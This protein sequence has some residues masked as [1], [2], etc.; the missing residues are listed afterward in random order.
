MT[1]YRTGGFSLIPNGARTTRTSG[2]SYVIPSAGGGTTITINEIG[3]GS[4]GTPGISVTFGINDTGAGTESY[5]ISSIGSL[6]DII[7]SSDTLANIF[8]SIPVNQAANGTDSLANL[9]AIV[10]VSDNINSSESILFSTLTSISDNGS[11][12]DSIT[13]ILNSF[14]LPETGTIVETIYKIAEGFILLTENGHFTET[15]NNF[16]VNFNLSEAGTG[17]DSLFNRVYLQVSETSTANDL[18][19]ILSA[20]LITIYESGNTVDSISNVGISFSLAESGSGNDI[21]AITNFL[22]ILDSAGANDVVIKLD[23]TE[24]FVQFVLPNRRIDFVLPARY[25]NFILQP[26]GKLK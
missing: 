16:S 23:G 24:L 11:F 19:N 2:F 12:S 18:V 21:L 3:A 26:R 5:P 10:P 17:V 22:T 9:T 1:V 20:S 25:T 7:N 15:I 6:N 14:S 4:D 13:N 8:A